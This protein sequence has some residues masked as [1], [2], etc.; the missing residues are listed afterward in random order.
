MDTEVIRIW[1][2]TSE[3]K[4]N[5][6]LDNPDIFCKDMVYL[7]NH[8]LST[9]ITNE[10]RNTLENLKQYIQTNQEGYIAENIAILMMEEN[11][12]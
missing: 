4:L 3:E 6:L 2:K 12:G 5:E 7:I 11:Y 10:V 9:P 8:H 1:N